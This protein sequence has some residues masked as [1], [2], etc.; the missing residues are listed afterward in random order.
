MRRPLIMSRW[1]DG[2]RWI[3]SAGVPSMTRRNLRQ[4]AGRPT[5]RKNSRGTAGVMKNPVYADD[6]SWLSA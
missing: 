5:L 4:S 1:S 2:A 3:R 6:A